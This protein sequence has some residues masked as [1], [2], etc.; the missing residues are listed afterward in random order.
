MADNDDKKKGSSDEKPKAEGDQALKG[1][2]SEVIGW[3]SNRSTELKGLDKRRMSLREMLSR[4]RPASAPYKH[5]DAYIWTKAILTWTNLDTLILIV[6][7]C[8]VWGAYI[9]SAS[10]PIYGLYAPTSI[11]KNI[12]DFYSIDPN[13]YYSSTDDVDRFIINTL[14]LL[15]RMDPDGKPFLPLLL[16]SVLPNIYQGAELEYKNYADVIKN[17]GLIQNLNITRI[18]KHRFNKQD[19]L[20]YAYVRGYLVT[21][22]VT[23]PTGVSIPPRIVIPYRAKVVVST[24]ILSNA[25]KSGFYLTWLEERLG[26]EEAL[27]W[28]K[29]QEDSEKK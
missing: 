2:A 19:K 3:L 27:A 22:Q 20:I 14:T 12:S 17:R 21:T 23:P 15:R 4:Q 6:I 28:D 11:N 5:F 7:A 16:G 1:I 13:S 18:Q 9:M 24:D 29:E 10:R 26:K 8:I 25:N